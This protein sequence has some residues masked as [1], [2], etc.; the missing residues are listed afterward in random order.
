ME[1]SGQNTPSLLRKRRKRDAISYPRGLRRC[2]SAIQSDEFVYSTSNDEFP[3]SSCPISGAFV[4]RDRNAATNIA[5]RLLL[6]G[7]NINNL[8]RGIKVE[9][10]KPIFWLN[11]KRTDHIVH[12]DRDVGSIAR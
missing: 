1:C 3:T 4:D 8:V 6:G 9:M 11:S 12:Y 2:C 10:R 7:D 5:L